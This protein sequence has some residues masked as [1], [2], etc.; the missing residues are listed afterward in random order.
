M[1]LIRTELE[2][3]ID[4]Q[5]IKAR[6]LLMKKEVQERR[7]KMTIMKFE[8]HMKNVL[9]MTQEQINGIVLLTE[10]ER[11]RLMEEEDQI[12][13][14]LQDEL[15]EIQPELNPNELKLKR[16]T[17]SEISVIENLESQIGGSAMRNNGK[18]AQ[19]ESNRETL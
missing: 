10:D 19:D 1:D 12:E 6:S 2:N 14:D 11:L 13:R 8:A 5:K 16:A 15:D 9:S 7:L 4:A 17:T 18:G 3:E